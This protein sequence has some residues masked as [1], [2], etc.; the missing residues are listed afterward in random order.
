MKKFFEIKENQQKL[1]QEIEKWVGTPYLHM[2]TGRGGLDCTKFVGMIFL[3]LGII[4]DFDKKTFYPCDWYAH[5]SKEV[6]LLS[7]E[8]TILKHLLPRYLV[9][10]IDYQDTTSIEVGDLLCIST[11]ARKLVNHTAL[12][13]GDD[14]IAH[15]LQ[16][17]GVFIGQFGFSYH[18]KTK[19]I[20]RLFYKEG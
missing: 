13:L 9:K 4:Q 8:N 2:G 6:C 3:G 18:S 15:C 17:K 20:F 1:L 7:I 10:K 14:K 19:N 12:Y 16:G 11:T 5:S